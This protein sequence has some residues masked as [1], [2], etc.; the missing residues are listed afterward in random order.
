MLVRRISHPNICGK[1][2]QRMIHLEYDFRIYNVLWKAVSCPWQLCITLH[3]YIWNNL[4]NNVAVSKNRKNV[5][6][7]DVQVIFFSFTVISNV[8]SS[9][10]P[11]ETLFT[12]YCLTQ[13]MSKLPGRFEIN[14]VRQY[15]V[16]FTGLAGIINA[17]VYKTEPIF[18]GLRH[19]KLS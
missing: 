18:T 8:C 19:D 17:I 10:I 13:W 9:F 12:K 3:G 15:R 11:N 2:C 6:W 1:Y 5:Y 7:S 4:L 16:N 14:W